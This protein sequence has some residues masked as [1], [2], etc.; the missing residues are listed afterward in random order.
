M[1][2]EVDVVGVVES[3]PAHGKHR[4][5]ELWQM[6]LARM[7]NRVPAHVFATWFRPS[8]ALSLEGKDL[9]L[10]VPSV[11]HHTWLK[12]QFGAEI[13]TEL[14][15]E[16][17]GCRLKLI[18]QAD[19][20]EDTPSSET[21]AAQQAGPLPVVVAPSGPQRERPPSNLN[22]RYTFENYVAGP[23][24]QF[25]YA[26]AQAVTENLARSYN[27]LF[28]FGS[29][30]LGKTH[31]CHAIGNRIQQLRP[32]LNIRY[33]S[34]EDFTNEVIES[35]QHQRMEHFRS[36]YRSLCDVLVIDD[37][38]FIAGKERTQ[39]EF[40]HSFNHLH[41]MGKQVVVTSDRFPHEMD[42]MEE[43]LRTRLQW[44]LIADIQPPE[45]ETRMAILRSK[46]AHQGVT[47]PDDVVLFLAS[48][49]K[50]N[51]RELEGSLLRLIAASSFK[52]R[53]LDLALCKEELRD[54]VLRHARVPTC[55]DII[56][57]VS[58]FYNVNVTELRGAK[59]NRAITTPRHMAM[60][61]CRKHTQA[62]FPEIGAAFGGKDHTTVM[63]S[64]RKMEELIKT[65]PAVVD[66]V[67]QLGKIIDL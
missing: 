10:A 57:H 46:A 23:S 43:R 29:V 8:R 6:V 30:G 1:L 47:L 51:V 9:T 11:F 58:S 15:K 20:Q 36:R 3:A 12:D 16:E 38:H 49:I 7:S 45:T 39:E 55:A 64:V 19:L 27:P 66:H 42:G 50:N 24:N 26:A 67:T 18:I 59:R 60:Y 28:L 62:S 32:E 13:E 4:A 21:L 2:P 52:R 48:H 33:V 65:D 25:A 56:K 61:L 53:A 41:Q 14:R 35:I 5:A 44:G 31:L 17:P 54:A 34:G 63:A 22:A 40:F 37:I